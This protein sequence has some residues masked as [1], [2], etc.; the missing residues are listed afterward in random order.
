MMLYTAGNRHYVG[1]TYNYMGDIY[2]EMLKAHHAGEMKKVV[3]LEGEADAIYKII[4]NTMVLPQ[5]R[6]SCVSLA[7]I[8]ERVRKPLK[9]FTAS[10]RDA[11]L[12]ILEQHNFLST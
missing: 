9:A 11:L 6:K 8:A 5:E 12:S 10:D 7:S 4:L 2:Q 3:N 1:S